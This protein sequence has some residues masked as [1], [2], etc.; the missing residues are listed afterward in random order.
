MVLIDMDRKHNKKL[1]PFARKLRKNMTKEENHLWYD[2]L[3]DYPVKF[4]R[5]KII[6]KY[7]VDFYC[8]KAKLAVELDGSQHYDN[9]DIFKH[10]EIRTEYLKQYGI[11]VIR[12]KNYE[13]YESFDAVCFYIE[14][15]V[16]QQLCKPASPV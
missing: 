2:F 8:A 10:D 6:G 1:V 5:Q 9:E 14:H 3:R 7:I 4:T 16:N 11:K 12:I 13:I 15:E